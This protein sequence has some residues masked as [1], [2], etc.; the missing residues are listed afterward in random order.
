[1]PKI[2]LVEDNGPI[3]DVIMRGLTAEGYAV[4]LAENGKVALS[5]A[6]STSYPLIV[7]D[8]ML[9]GLDGLEVCRLL[10]Q[11]QYRG[12]ILM[13]TVRG[14]I[15]D[16]VEGL[17][18]GADD[19]LTKPFAFEEL[20]ARMEALLRRDE[21]PPRNPVLKVDDLVL[22][23]RTKRVTR[24]GRVIALTAKEFDLLSY[25]MQNAGS[26]VSRAE[27]LARVWRLDPASETK[28]VDVYIGY[29]RSKL[30]LQD[31]GSLIRTVR[32]F[33]Y[34]IGHDGADEDAKALDEET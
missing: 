18:S 34:V 9:P 20:L 33:G 10:R 17:N 7:L 30:D 8:R 31:E 14:T 22:D 11:S 13:L 15:Q 21:R 28:V 2:L 4:D 12:W 5:L 19:Y 1:L 27:L 24:G 16:K 6:S 26:V 32:G 23:D 3:A 29:L 25:L